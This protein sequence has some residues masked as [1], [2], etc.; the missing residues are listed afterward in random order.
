MTPLLLTCATS[1]EAP[2]KPLEAPA[3]PAADKPNAQK[4]LGQALPNDVAICLSSLGVLKGVNIIVQP[5]IEDDVLEHYFY[6]CLQRQNPEMIKDKVKKMLFKF[7]TTTENDNRCFFQ[8]GKLH[9][10][11]SDYL[12]KTST[13][14]DKTQMVNRQVQEFLEICLEGLSK[15]KI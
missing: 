4:E 3:I 5:S 12:T 15:T 1:A 8:A 2:P 7:S 9:Q 11:L 10:E 14:P 6:D 13:A